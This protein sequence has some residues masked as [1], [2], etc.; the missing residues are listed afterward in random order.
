MRTE[1][2]FVVARAITDE[3]IIQNPIP[4]IE[5]TKL[6][7]IVAKHSKIDLKII[8]ASWRAISVYGYLRRYKDR[9]EVIYSAELND[10]WARFVVCKELIHVLIDIEDDY[11]TDPSELVRQLTTMERNPTNDVHSEYNAIYGAIELLLPVPYRTRAR[12]MSTIGKSDYDV[13][14]HFKI[15]EKIISFIL[16]DAFNVYEEK[17]KLIKRG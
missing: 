15:P 8:M 17:V 13:A 16:S 14:Y 5:I 2:T 6:L 4:P 10:C 11:T 12:E 7:P 3:Y 1:E 9:A